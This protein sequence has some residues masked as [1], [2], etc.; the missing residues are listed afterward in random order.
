M[1]FNSNAGASKVFRNNCIETDKTDIQQLGERP[2]IKRSKSD[3]AIILR[4]KSLARENEELL[5]S[6]VLEQV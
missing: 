3:P 5:I 6:H 2:I 4:L 1:V